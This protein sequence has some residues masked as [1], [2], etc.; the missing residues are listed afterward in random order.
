MDID[1]TVLNQALTYIVSG[2]GSSLV[3]YWLME[4]IPELAELT[5]QYK[6][7]ASLGLAAL[8]SCVAYLFSVG[9]NYISTPIGLQGW[10]EALFAVS[11]LAVFGSQSL[12]GKRKL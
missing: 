5:S 6:R 7:F 12:H 2:G 9:L 1:T 11:F 3:T 10:L 8:L 4:N